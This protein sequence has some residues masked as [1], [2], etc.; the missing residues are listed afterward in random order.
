[1]EGRSGEEGLGLG[2]VE[3]G[4]AAAPPLPSLIVAAG[5]LAGRQGNEILSKIPHTSPFLIPFSL[6]VSF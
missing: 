6:V 4:P 2:L 3:V 5:A 1:M